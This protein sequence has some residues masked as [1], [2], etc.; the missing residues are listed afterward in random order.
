M[1]IGMI[2]SMGFEALKV[3]FSGME[4]VLLAFC[5]AFLISVILTPI[6]IPILKRL[7]FGQTIR[8]IGPSWH[9]KK[10]GTP[11]MGGIGFV[12]ATAVAVLVFAKG[13]MKAILGVIAVLAFGII[14]FADDY[15]KVV[16][17]RNLGLT[18]IQKLVLQ[19]LASVGFLV[20]AYL[21]GFIDTKLHIPFTN[22]SIQLS[23]FYFLFG[24]FFMVGFVN[25]VNLTDGVDGLA[26]SVTTLIALFF[27]LF[28]SKAESMG[29]AV[30]CAAVAGGVFAFLFYN[31]NPAKV[32]M[33]DTG[34]LFLGGVVSVATVLLR[35]ELLLV[36]VGLIY[37]IEAVSVMIQVAYFKKTGKRVFLMTPIHHHFEKKGWKENKIVT[38]FS[39]ITLICCVIAFLA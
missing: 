29:V 32:F 38:V 18:E 17:K 25:A 22:I 4:S 3:I 28:A 35:C 6:L 2:K 27:A 1:N 11:T 10:N 39:L 37:L 21:L 13:D 24:T 23:W 26:G 15:I 16:L 8:E 36:L 20:A 5:A 31:F 19:I 30:L 12:I 34:S 9:Q 33:G 7:K 14:G